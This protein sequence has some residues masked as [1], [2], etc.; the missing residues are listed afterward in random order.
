MILV[1]GFEF[2]LADHYYTV[3][4]IAISQTWYSNPK[5]DIAEEAL[6][7]KEDILR[8]RLDCRESN[9]QI[10]NPPTWTNGWL[11]TIY[12]LQ[13][14]EVDNRIHSRFRTKNLGGFNFDFVLLQLFI[15][16]WL[17]FPRRM[18]IQHDVSSRAQPSTKTQ[19]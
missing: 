4:S 9:G 17:Y 5:A 3:P 14:H 19:S 8:N 2:L 10:H 6:G 15:C 1:S 16:V 12:E 11:A 13:K 7:G 18:P